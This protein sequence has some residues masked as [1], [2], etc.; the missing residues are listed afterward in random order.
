MN[1]DELKKLAIECGAYGKHDMVFTDTEL[2]DYT[3]AVEAPLQARI[4]QLQK[5]LDEVTCMKMDQSPLVGA[6]RLA[7]ENEKANARI[8]QLEEALK[9]CLN[10]PHTNGSKDVVIKALEYSPSTWLSE[11]DKA[12]EARERERCADICQS[13]GDEWKRLKV[14]AYDGRYDMME[15]AASILEDEI[16]ELK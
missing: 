10:H 6:L 1:K 12:V 8:A 5:K 9:P 2:E 7:Y 11:H 3:A 15:E 4:A 16:R 13:Y 14:G